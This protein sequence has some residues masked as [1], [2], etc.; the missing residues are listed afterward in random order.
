MSWH[1]GSLRKR[2]TLFFVVG[3]AIILTSLGVASHFIIQ[4][5][6][7]DTLTRKLA[8]SRLIRNNI[9]NIIKDNIN[10]L[11]DISLSGVM[12]LNNPH[13]TAGMEAIKAA[14]RYSIFTD[15]VFLIDKGGNVLLTYPERIRENSLNVLSIEP[16][17]RMLALGQPVVSNLYTVEPTKKKV[18]YV[19]VPL[20]DKNGNTIGAAGG[21]I[22]PTNPVLIQKLGLIDIGKNEFIDIVDS[23]GMVVASSSP[24]RMFTQCDRNSFFST[25]ISERKEQVATCHVCHVAQHR[26][27]KLTTIVAFVPLETAPWGVSVQEPERD[28]FA[29]S[30]ELKRNLTVLG[31]IFIVTALLLTVGINRSIV[32]PLKELIGG[33]DHIS[34][35]DLTLSISPQG[36]DEIGVLSR[37]FEIMRLKLIESRD[38]IVRQNM[39]LEHRVR[40]R[41]RQIRDSQKRSE[42]LLKKVIS[43]QEDERKRIGR[44]LHDDTLQQLSAV[45]MRIDMCKLQPQTFTPN[46]VEELRGI[47]IT[48]IDSIIAIMQNLRPTLL[49]DLGLTAAI[50]SLVDIHLGEKGI[51]YNVDTIG[52]TDKRFRPEVEITL[53]RIVQEAISNIGRHA[54]AKNV[55]VLIKCDHD[56]VHVNIE[57]NGVG[58]EVNSLYHQSSHDMRDRRGL[59]ILGMKERV[60]LIGGEMDIHSQPG[61]G[62]KIGIRIPLLQ[63]EV[64]HA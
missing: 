55:S 58:F 64:K 38:S 24:S 36:S 10:R 40:E 29:S 46:K 39:E 4:K 51:K 43:S 52:M 22:N 15:G 27:E 59:G 30:M 25:I 14:Y 12:D 8:L 50:K 16:V 42:M 23:N 9:D 56:A 45:L 57:D 19:L 34:K 49:D 32:N 53:F 31:V 35:G 6:I 20:R 37:S 28:V 47:V 62:T 3:I 48:A 7:N 41:T 63:A 61:I 26:E 54:K 2:I 60:I 17:S 11:Y 18:L 5:N 33:T 21:Q 1:K 44:E 13:S